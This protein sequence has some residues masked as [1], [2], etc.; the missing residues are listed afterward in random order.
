MN[1]CLN[2]AFPLLMKSIK[3]MTQTKAILG[4]GNNHLLLLQAVLALGAAVLSRHW[5][6]AFVVHD[7]QHPQRNRGEGRIKTEYCKKPHIVFTAKCLLGSEW[8]LPAACVGGGRAV[9]LGCYG[10]WI[11]SSSSSL[12]E[13]IIWGAN[14]A[15]RTFSC[16]QKVW[17]SH[18][19]TSLFYSI[20]YFSFCLFKA[21]F[22]VWLQ[23]E[24]PLSFSA[25]LGIGRCFW[26]SQSHQGAAPGEAG[27]SIPLESVW[28]SVLPFFLPFIILPLEMHTSP[29][30]IQ[31]P[32]MQSSLR[33]CK[34]S[35]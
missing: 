33:V 35:Q 8:Q 2:R 18:S 30:V 5:K 24:V 26:A 22:M 6:N 32:A 11:A 9:S 21:C 4:L 25:V 7:V 10:P 17:I 3:R 14:V 29:R 23:G 27:A 13:S 12:S 28:L 15:L 31:A 16:V 20:L 1:L 34:R 19:A